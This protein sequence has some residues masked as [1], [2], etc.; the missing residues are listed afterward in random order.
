MAA[1]QY[2]QPTVDEA[3]EA[4]VRPLNAKEYQ[5]RCIALWRDL[6]GDAFADHVRGLAL[7]KLKKS[8]GTR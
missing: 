6:Y 7:A 1:V 4:L 8:K 2:R 5:V 3:V